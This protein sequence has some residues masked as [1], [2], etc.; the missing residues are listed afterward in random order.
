MTV[1]HVGF[2]NSLPD[3][4]RELVREENEVDNRLKKL[5]TMMEE[6]DMNDRLIKIENMMEEIENKLQNHENFIARLQYQIKSLEEDIKGLQ[7]SG[8]FTKEE[9]ETLKSDILK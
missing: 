1:G 4:I 3:Q 8:I 9:I 7:V 5:E 6:I 2:G